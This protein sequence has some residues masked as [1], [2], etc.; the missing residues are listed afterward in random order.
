VPSLAQ[1]RKASR[2]HLR[3]YCIIY[4]TIRGKTIT[5]LVLHPL[6]IFIGIN[7]GGGWSWGHYIRR[8]CNIS[9]DGG[10]LTHLIFFFIGVTEDDDLP[11]LGGPRMLRL[12]SLKSLLVNSSSHEVSRM[13]PSSSTDEERSTTGAFLEGPPAQTLVSTGSM[14]KLSVETPAVE[15][16]QMVPPVESEHHSVTDFPP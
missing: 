13:R 3:R 1:Q 10:L 11:S 2:L 4:L 9:I 16:I 8:W 12:W 14:R 15:V 5:I 6:G 7:N